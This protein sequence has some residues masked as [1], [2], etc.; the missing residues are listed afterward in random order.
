MKRLLY[1]T[2]FIMFWVVLNFTMGWAQTP[3]GPKMVIKEK[4]FDAQ[5]VREG[6]IIVHD[7]KVFNTGDSPLEIEKVRPG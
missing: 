5:E 4:S 3:T 1:V 7:F 6:E 2:F